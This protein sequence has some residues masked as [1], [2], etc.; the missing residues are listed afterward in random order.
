MDNCFGIV[1]SSNQATGVLRG[2]HRRMDDP[3]V[4]RNRSVVAACGKHTYTLLSVAS[5]WKM[6]WLAG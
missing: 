1:K 6:T 2:L 3:M 4:I 5:D